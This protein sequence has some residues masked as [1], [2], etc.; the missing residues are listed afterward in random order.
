MATYKE[1]NGQARVGY[2]FT[3]KEK[4]GKAYTANLIY[5]VTKIV[6]EKV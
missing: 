3:P 1:T 5:E 4:R 2:V 6:L